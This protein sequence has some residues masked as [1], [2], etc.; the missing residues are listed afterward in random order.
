MASNTVDQFSGL[1]PELKER[2]LECESPEE[3]LALAREE[4][5]ELTDEQIEGI[6]GG[7]ILCFSNE[8]EGPVT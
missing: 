7:W 8:G 6:A 4:G 3:L 1:A 2:A 5:F